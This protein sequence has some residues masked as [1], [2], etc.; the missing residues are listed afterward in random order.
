MF[1]RFYLQNAIIRDQSKRDQTHYLLGRNNRGLVSQNCHIRRQIRTPDD[2]DIRLVDVWM[3]HQLG[4]PFTAHYGL[5]VMD[6]SF[7]NTKNFEQFYADSQSVYSP[8]QGEYT[9]ESGFFGSKDYIINQWKAAQRTIINSLILSGQALV[10]CNKYESFHMSGIQ[11]LRDVQGYADLKEKPKIKTALNAKRD[12]ET[13]KKKVVRIHDL[14]ETTQEEVVN[15]IKTQTNPASLVPNL[16]GW[17]EGV[18]KDSGPDT[19][20][21]TFLRCMFPNHKGDRGDEKTHLYSVKTYECICDDFRKSRI[22][23]TYTSWLFKSTITAKFRD[24]DDERFSI[25]DEFGNMMRVSHYG[26]DSLPGVCVCKGNETEYVKFLKKSKHKMTSGHTIFTPF[27]GT[28][29]VEEGKLNVSHL[30]YDLFTDYLRKLLS[31]L[32][33]ARI[34]YK[35]SNLAMT[36]ATQTPPEVYM[37]HL[38]FMYVTEETGKLLLELTMNQ[39]IELLC[40][41]CVLYRTACHIIFDMLVY[42]FKHR[43]KTMKIMAEVTE[44]AKKE[45]YEAARIRRREER[46]KRKQE[47]AAEA[48]L[49]KSAKKRKQAEY[50]EQ[51]K[52]KREED[53]LLFEQQQKKARKDAEAQ[54][55]AQVQAEWD[56]QKKLRES[57]PDRAEYDKKRKKGFGSSKKKKRVIIKK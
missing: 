21:T 44:K 9:V 36:D 24:E 54:A 32:A 14:S 49:T 2:H 30:M 13:K 46:E 41:L 42:T 22:D 37:K 39:E 1:S 20:V 43:E 23:K 55:L 19:T 28:H 33:T 51:R 16:P 26:P 48:E 47:M 12:I 45:A 25:A 50:D 5:K 3:T 17:F 53:S 34:L 29:C 11:N 15:F 7:M 6:L 10:E 18:I 56:A 35:D 40:K 27:D 31:S 57:T 52:R 8:G 38:T 4:Y